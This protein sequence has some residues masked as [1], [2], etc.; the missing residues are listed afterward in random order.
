MWDVHFPPTSLSRACSQEIL[1]VLVVSG[2]GLRLV[3][4]VLRGIAGARFEAMRRFA[5]VPVLA[6]SL[7]LAY[8]FVDAA[9]PTPAGGA[10]SL[11]D[12]AVPRTLVA[13]NI[14]I[15]EFA[16]DNQRL[17][18]MT[19]RCRSAEG[20]PVDQV[21]LRRVAG[22]RVVTLAQRVCGYEG[23]SGLA[24]AGTRAVFWWVYDGGNSTYYRVATA[25][26]GKAQR[27]IGQLVSS[28]GFPDVRM[29]DG[30]GKTLV[31]AQARGE[32][33]NDCWSTRKTCVWEVSGGDVWRVA[34]RRAVRIRG[35]PV[36]AALAASST[37][38]AIA[39]ALRRWSGRQL[40]SFVPAAVNGP[41]EIRDPHTSALRSTF[42]PR[43][44]VL[45]LALAGR[46]AA[47]LVSRGSGRRIERYAVPSGRLLEGTSVP[48]SAR[49]IDVAGNNVVY[50]VGNAIWLF[51]GG[52][53]ALLTRALA[54]PIGLSIDN[55]RIAWAENVGSHGRIES[56]TLPR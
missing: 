15:S 43:G 20:R 55:Q 45:D 33:A 23:L 16:Q 36:P 49:D 35:V 7:L 30:D 8:S 12:S 29:V 42:A 17:A 38:I 53:S 14:P 2:R 54:R 40:P 3:P 26:V 27:D 50:R 1:V 13:L 56:I 24:L 51:S 52:R 39:P 10:G 18:W 22:G 44:R 9:G 11:G 19:G 32:V 37:Q 31:Y 46:S 48:S 47:V 21:A 6:V 25:A 5:R 41:V 28:P 4:D 34:E